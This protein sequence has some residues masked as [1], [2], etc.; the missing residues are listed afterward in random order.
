MDLVEGQPQNVAAVAVGALE[1]EEDGTAVIIHVRVTDDALLRLGEHR[2]VPEGV[3]P[4]GEAE[5]SAGAEIT[6]RLGIG[7]RLG[8]GVV[9]AAHHKM[10]RV[11]QARELG[12]DAGQTA[13]AALRAGGAVGSKSGFAGG[14]SCRPRLLA[15]DGGGDRQKWRA[16]AASDNRS[17]A[18]PRFADR[19]VG[20]SGSG[21]NDVETR[22][23]GA[24]G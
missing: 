11:D 6:L 20:G 8:V 12:L 18:H 1:G 15:G 17:H 22:H 7:E 3:A 16:H 19:Y 4:F 23:A 2:L 10:A 24:P 21:F 5:L 14:R 13:G 9:R